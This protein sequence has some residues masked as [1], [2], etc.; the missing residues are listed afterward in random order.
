MKDT[1]SKSWLFSPSLTWRLAPQTQFTARYEYYD[2]ESSNLEGIPVDPSVGTN[3]GFKTLEGVPLDFNSAPDDR[4]SF[5]R[6][7]THALNVLFTSTIT[8][9]LSVRLAGRIAEIDT[10]NSDFRWGL[11]TPGGS[12]NP[13]TGAWEGG[14]IW[15]NASTDPLAPNWVADPAPALSDTITHVGTYS[16]AWRRERDLQNDWSYI[17]DS[18]LAKSTTLLG[19][20]YSYGHQNSQNNTQRLP[21]FAVAGFSRPGTAPV[22]DPVT[23]DNRGLTT[24]Y[25]AYLSEVLEL[26]NHRLVL[27]GGVSHVS[28]NSLNGNKL[29]AATSDSVAGQL[30]PTSGSKATCNYG[31]VVKALP[32]A[33][34]YYGHSESANPSTGRA[35]YLGTRPNFSVG[36]QDEVGLKVQLFENRLIASI[37]YYEIDQS[38]YAVFNPANLAVPPPTPQLP[39]LVL[40]REASGWEFQVTGSLTPS[41]SIIASYAD[42]KN[43]D[44]RGVML[45]GS[46]EDTAALFVRYGVSSGPLAGLSAGI[47]VNYS[48][49]RA[50]DNPP[51]GYTALSTPDNLIPNLPSFYLP[52]RTLANAYVSYARGAW[53]YRLDVNNLTDETHYTSLSRSIIQVGNP[54]NV[55]AS[56]TYT[57]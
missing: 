8:E 42:T 41:L 46:P 49:K 28:F 40:S 50:G 4:Y 15:R 30:Y 53:S 45:R 37:A 12:R 23:T 55:S 11:S 21:S 38:S 34:L 7:L 26:F 29:A 36:K 27:S 5:R 57:F 3:T 33:A 20:A 6:G 14:V 1:Y 2:A 9:N 32:N 25:Q 39:D 48:S 44:P 54:R 17:V 24:R 35:V 51:G 43:R 56:V 31:V 52:S 16:T 19:F 13:H 18:D 10:P 47:G 22:S